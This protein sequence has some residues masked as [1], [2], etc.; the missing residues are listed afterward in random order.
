MRAFGGLRAPVFLRCAAAA[1]MALAVPTESLAQDALHGKRLYLDAARVRGSGVS[2]VDCHGGLPGGLF[3][4]GRAANDP[5]AVERAVN[6]VPQMTPLRG[7]LGAQDYADLAAYLGNPTVP[8]PALR[9]LVSGPAAT[10]SADRLDFGVVSRNAQSTASRWHIV[11]EGSVG[12]T[13]TGA[14]QL[15]GHH[16]QDFVIIASDC[17]AGRTL[18]A[19][20]SCSVDLAFRPL[21]GVDT[22]QAAVAVAHDWVG[23]EAAVALAGAVVAAPV[24]PAPSASAGGGGGGA[25]LGLLCALLT[26]AAARRR[27]LAGPATDYRS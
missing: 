8:S 13:V 18:M 22:R 2:C 16:P 4:I 5:A 10:S 7:R 24:S 9:S 27:C 21:D 26:A 14:P 17:S 20:A 15:R 23:G 3:G 12:L 25:A 19:G 6:A 11:N 1:L